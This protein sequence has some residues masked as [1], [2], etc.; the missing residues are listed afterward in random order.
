MATRAPHWFT[1]LARATSRA[2]GRP[3]TFGAAVL[4]IVGWALAGPFFGFGAGWE[5]FINTCTTIVTFLMVFL[6]QNRQNR[7]AEAV[8]VKLS[9]L[10]RALAGA[11]NALVDLEGLDDTE[12]EALHE[13]Y[14]ALAERARA[15]ARHGKPDTGVDDV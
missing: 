8:Q 10:I 4:L 5:L 2:S 11:Q 6:I 7:D 12:L 3:G 15:R 9:E 1:R 14:A 13:R